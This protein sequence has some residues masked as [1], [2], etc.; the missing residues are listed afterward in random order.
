MAVLPLMAAVTWLG[1]G[2]TALS[3]ELFGDGELAG[4]GAA[5]AG[6]G[7]AGQRAGAPAEG[8][9]GVG[10][11]G[12]G[13]IATTPLA[14]NG[15]LPLGGIGGFPTTPP[16]GKF[17]G[18]LPLP[19]ITFP[20]M[21]TDAGVATQVACSADSTYRGSVVI[22]SAADI[23]RIKGCRR[24]TGDLQIAAAAITD[25][26]GLEGLQE[27]DGMLQIA[28]M[29]PARAGDAP[30][31]G[32]SALTDLSGLSG[33]T[34]LG[35]LDLDY[36]SIT[37]LAAFG[38][39][40]SASIVHFS[41]LD[42]LLD[43]SGLGSLG[44]DVQIEIS[45]SAS[46]MTLNGLQ[47][48]HARTLT[49]SDDPK[50]VDLT[51]AVGSDGVGLGELSLTNLPSLTRLT[52]LESAPAATSI[53]I[54]QC[55]AL[56]DLSGLDQLQTI[57]NLTL[58]D[59]QRFATL[60]GAPLLSAIRQALVLNRLPAFSSAVGLSKLTTM[61]ELQVSATRVLT[62]L[63]GF[64]SVTALSSLE[65]SDNVA[66]QN[67]KGIDNVKQIDSVM[68]TRNSAL[69][70]LDGLPKLDR[71]QQL[72][73]DSNPLL[74][75]LAALSSYLMID[76]ISVTSDEALV[77]FSGLEQL[78]TVANTFTITGDSSLTSLH[79]LKS[80]T[81]IGSLQLARNQRL[82]QC[83]IDWLTAQAHIATVMGDGPQGTCP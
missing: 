32:V 28:P 70:S 33:L 53:Q 74:T 51:G 17:D 68:L 57:G 48:Q 5:I 14:G 43:L 23:T 78:S 47:F 60:S 19:P 83:E 29:L 12:A 9:A 36:L 42:G 76:A 65:V 67:L 59:D 50:L 6:S 66:L 34:T 40:Q 4:S 72:M 58:V 7:A 46:L 30:G 69:Q 52:G 64:E 77:D 44:S 41:H 2:S 73:L 39:L 79:A 16:N 24:I 61:Q 71:L 1:C 45:D 82:P 22:R 8:T 13:R 80:L 55:D 26:Q 35:A 25:L 20:N 10:R 27:V 62:S 56:L 21:P 75:S 37:S 49:L 15:S 3:T 63:T 54:Q 81:K 31:A 18:G 38:H 11:G